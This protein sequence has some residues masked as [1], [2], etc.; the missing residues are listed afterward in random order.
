MINKSPLK[1]GTNK[2]W[3]LF[4]NPCLHRLYKNNEKELG[5]G[6]QKMAAMETSSNTMGEETDEEVEATAGEK[7]KETNKDCELEIPNLV[8]VKARGENESTSSDMGVEDTLT[9]SGESIQA[10]AS[11]SSHMSSKHS[12]NKK[13][14]KVGEL[15][16]LE[17]QIRIYAR[18]V[19]FPEKKFLESPKILLCDQEPEKDDD[20]QKGVVCRD[21]VSCLMKQAREGVDVV[22]FLLTSSTINLE[23]LIQTSCIGCTSK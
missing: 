10:S 19:L 18:D 2:T 22:G 16:W 1:H 23:G 14:R 12:V 17:L 13:K 20:P 21:L 5:E 3:S 7:A 8:D 9:V 11:M 15:S 4:C 6:P